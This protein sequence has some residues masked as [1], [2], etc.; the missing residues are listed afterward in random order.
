M[1]QACRYTI[2]ATCSLSLTSKLRAQLSTDVAPAGLVL[3]QCYL[4]A[5]VAAAVLLCT[6]GR[7]VAERSLPHGVELRLQSVG[8]AAS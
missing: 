8:A 1:V 5:A 6:V 2:P 4:I 3:H 7:V